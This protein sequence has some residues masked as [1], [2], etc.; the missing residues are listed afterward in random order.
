MSGSQTAV[1]ASTLS[2]DYNRG[3]MMDGQSLPRTLMSGS[4]LCMLANRVSWYYNFLGPSV[5]VDTACSGSM[6]GLDLACKSIYAGD[7]SMV[8]SCATIVKRVACVPD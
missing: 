4:Y 7:A 1:F 6:V 8:R 2:D 5:F 3:A